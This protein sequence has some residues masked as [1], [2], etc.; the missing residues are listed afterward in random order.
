MT[1]PPKS[2]SSDEME[3]KDNHMTGVQDFWVVT[4]SN[5]AEIKDLWDHMLRSNTKF[6]TKAETKNMSVGLVCFSSARDALMICEH[7]SDFQKT[8]TGTS[9]SGTE[10]T[11]I[12]C[13]PLSHGL[14]VRAYSKWEAVVEWWSIGSAQM[15]PAA[16]WH[17]LKTRSTAK[18]Y[19]AI[20]EIEPM[21][22]RNFANFG[23]ITKTY[24]EMRPGALQGSLFGFE[25]DEHTQK[26]IN[27]IHTQGSS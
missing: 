9:G 10:I 27:Y 6:L 3:K 24:D 23:A 4:T 25:N 5:G 15:T 1:V 19:K 13:N 12:Q 14:K 11:H 16:L 18:V 2:L 17:H 8:Q 7:M 22:Y 21:A 26:Y 20:L